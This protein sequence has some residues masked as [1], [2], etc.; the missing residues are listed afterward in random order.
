MTVKSTIP[1]DIYQGISHK[2]EISLLKMK[3]SLKV[4]MTDNPTSANQIH[5]SSQNTSE[6][7]VWSVLKTMKQGRTLL[8]IYLL[9]DRTVSFGILPTCSA[10]ASSYK[11]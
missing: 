1:F 7:S 6:K 5:F 3:P 9:S 8:R 2:T 11:V 10:S 4:R